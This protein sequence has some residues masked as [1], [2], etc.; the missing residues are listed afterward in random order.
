MNTTKLS[1][2]LTLARELDLALYRYCLAASQSTQQLA[3][4]VTLHLGEKKH[5]V[6]TRGL[7]YYP[8]MPSGSRLLQVLLGCSNLQMCAAAISG[9]EH[10]T[11][12]VPQRCTV[13]NHRSH[14]DRINAVHTKFCFR[15]YYYLR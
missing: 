8:D 14:A 6:P 13:L 3:S 11:T 1:E 2:P 12:M 10:S 5:H 4:V 7:L 9:C 15:Y